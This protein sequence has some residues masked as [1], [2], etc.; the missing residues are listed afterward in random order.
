[1]KDFCFLVS[2]GRGVGREGGMT[3]VFIM[4]SRVKE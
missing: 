1:M 2:L 4:K 3:P